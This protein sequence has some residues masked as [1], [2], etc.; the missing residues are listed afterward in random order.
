MKPNEKT[1]SHQGDK[2][3]SCPFICATLKAQSGPSELLWL[4]RLQDVIARKLV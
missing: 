2:N 3:Q 1:I 4:H